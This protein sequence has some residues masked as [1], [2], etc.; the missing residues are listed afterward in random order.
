MSDVSHIDLKGIG[1]SDTPS[2]KKVERPMYNA[3]FSSKKRWFGEQAPVLI[4]F[5]TESTLF[6]ASSQF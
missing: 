1:V 2:R 4:K 3:S 6:G 5:L